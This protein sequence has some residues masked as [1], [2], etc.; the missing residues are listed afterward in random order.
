MHWFLKLVILP[1]LDAL[2][3]K[4]IVEVGVEVGA[5]TRPL[6]AW[7]Q[8]HDA[9]LHCIDPDPNL[10]VDELLA[11]YGERLQFHRDKS[12]SVLGELSAVDLALIDGDHNW[13]TVINELRALERRALDDERPPPLVLVHDIGWP[14]GRRDLYYDPQS[15]PEAH[16]H[17]HARQ[18]IVLG[19][20][21]LGLG[22]NEHL[23]NAVI[24]NTPA[25]GVLSAV[26]DFV[27]DSH[28]DWQS[29]SIPG[30]S[31]LAIVATRELLAG[32]PDVAS[33]LARI[34]TPE[35]LRAQC[36]A[37][38]YARLQEELKRAQLSRRLAETQL[39]QVMRRVDPEELV[40]LHRRVRELQDQLRDA[41]LEGQAR[42]ELEAQVSLLA[43]EL[44]RAS[45][46]S[47]HLREA[48]A[49]AQMPGE[50]TPLEPP[51]PA[52]AIPAGAGGAA[53]DDAAGAA[54]NSEREARAIFLEQFMPVLE[55]AFPDSTGRD[56]LALPAP[57]DPLGVLV[58]GGEL[59]LPDAPTVDVVV[60][61]HDA[62][63]DLR[64]CLWSLTH[65]TGRPFRLIVVDDG[66]EQAT[67]EYLDAFAA[68]LPAV[69]LIRRTQ[70]PHGYTLAAN[71]GLKA[72]RCDYVVLLN[73]DTVVSPGWLERILARGERD[74]H[75]GILGPLSNAAS[76]QSVPELRE[77]GAWATNPL[78]DWLTVDGAAFAIER[79]PRVGALLPFL[80]GFC[81]AIKRSVI[82][83]IGYL[84]EQTFPGGYCEENDY[85]Q[86]ARDA[87]FELAVV[88]DAYVYHS[89]SRSFG[90][91][92]REELARGNYELFRA[93]HGPELIDRLVSEMEAETTL[94]P[95]RAAF[96]ELTSGPGAL[97]SSLTA[98]G[99]RELPIVFI[100]PG[101]PYGGSGGSHSVYQEVK[102]LR[103]LGIPAQIAL[104]S[105]DW[106]RAQAAYPDADEVFR[107]FTDSDDLAAVTADAAVISATHYRSVSLV[108]ELR[109]MREDFLPAY[110][111]QDYE[112]FFTAPHVAEEA[113][114]SY[115]SVPGMVLFAKSHWLCN[116]VAERHGLLVEKVE[117]SIDEG[118]FTPGGQMRRRSGPLRVVAMV[119]PRTT[120]R[121]PSST[122]EVLERLHSEL[123]ESVQITTFGCYA[124]ELGEIAPAARNTL[125]GH[126]GLLAREE[127]A[128]LLRR[129]DVFLDMS[130]Y[131]AFGRTALEAMACGCTALVPQVGGAWEFI[132]QGENG[133]AIDTLDPHSAVEALTSLAE[134]REQL[135]RLQAGARATAAPYSIARAALSEYLMFE[136]AHRA[137]FGG[138]D[139]SPAA[140]G[141]RSLLAH[142]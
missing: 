13:Y 34:D 95:S 67:S 15:I 108:R 14:Y 44:E 11:E 73:S 126:V 98:N 100:L 110:Y 127:V 18:G 20:A 80:N 46:E 6:L 41:E 64:R 78:P 104:P 136:R 52:N 42:E 23:E 130:V 30:L 55:R 88:D 1:L 102:G 53:T 21:E 109:E 49:R 87:G 24:E 132:E 26:E 128:E 16:R 77:D 90:T 68:R 45:A 57:L 71:A 139:H 9:L 133:L 113:V 81:F 91:G 84:D 141:A 142:E 54:A 94:S 115:T 79:G 106:E 75:V 101:L 83:T 4:V 118:L 96:A 125:D 99:E 69:E 129:S 40:G 138:P 61:V 122:V 65:K 63:E 50:S 112:P 107:T 25:N 66:S 7:A 58:G 121:Q 70:P 51:A 12:L 111:V 60:C 28:S 17:S 32:N 5:V 38:E 140:I 29:W 37:I 76:H 135:G 43:G 2:S 114:A 47:A 103:G 33:V 39:K 124:D 22:L 8:E 131:Q 97:A 120:R 123:G 62:L 85:S 116:V 35:F 89:K 10:N 36:E 74:E 137:R 82:D 27:A 134:D 119:R 93:K 3:P 56:P 19:Q 31:G 48:L 86:R 105:W 59:Q 117:P 92:G 72:S